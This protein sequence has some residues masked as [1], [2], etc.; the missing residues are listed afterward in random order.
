MTGQCKGVP[1]LAV[2]VQ[3]MMCSRF[4]FK[5]I[6][7]AMLEDPFFQKAP[8]R[9]EVPAGT[10]ASRPVFSTVCTASP[11]TG[12]EQVFR[13]SPASCGSSSKRL[14]DGG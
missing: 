6:G 5:C 1:R 9:M 4:A 14:A 2:W 7:M 12:L 11:E 13:P 10:Q 8:P 3:W